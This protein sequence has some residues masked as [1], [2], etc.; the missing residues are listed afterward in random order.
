MA[1]AQIPEGHS[2]MVEA[3]DERAA[4]YAASREANADFRRYVKRTLH[5]EDLG[6]GS[7]EVV[8]QLAGPM[9]TARTERRQFT[10]AERA[11]LLTAAPLARRYGR[12]AEPTPVGWAR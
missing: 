8:L 7:F 12:S 11:A 9:E 5:V 10:H 1:Q 4:Q 6:N 2:F 3:A